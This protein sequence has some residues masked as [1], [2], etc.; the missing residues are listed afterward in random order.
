LLYAHGNKFSTFYPSKLKISEYIPSVR[1]TDF[2]LFNKSVQIGP[3]DISPLQKSISETKQIVLSHE[4]SIFTFEFATLDYSAPL[5]NM[6]AHKMDGIDP[7]WVLSDATRRF[8]TYTNL[9]P[10]EYTFLVKGSNSHGVWNEKPTSIKVIINPP[11][12]QTSWAYLIYVILFCLTIYSLRAY[13]LKRQR[14]KH[15]LELEHEHAEELEQVDQMKSKFFANISHE[16]R[17]PLTLIEGPVKQLVEGSFSG[18]IK[19]QYRLILR[20][21]RRLLRMINQILDL[22]KIDAGHMNLRAS[23][24]NVVPLLKGLVMTFASKADQKNITIDLGIAEN[25]IPLFLDKEKFETIITNLMSNALKF[26]PENGKIGVSLRITHPPSSPFF[27]GEIDSPLRE[28]ENNSKFQISKAA[29]VEISISNT[30]PH[31]PPERLDKIFNRFSHFDET[32]HSNHESTGIGL[33]LTKELVELHKGS[34]QVMSTADEGTTFSLTF[35]LGSEHLTPD[36]ILDNDAVLASNDKPDFE[37]S[38]EKPVVITP[39]PQSDKPVILMVDDNDDVRQFVHS[40]LESSFS[41]IEAENGLKGYKSAA[42][43]IPDLIIS[44]V[45]MPEM[46]GFELC[47]KLKQDERT[48][49]IPVILLTARAATPDKLRGLE[50]GADDYIAKPF[51][52]EELLIR[53]RNLIDQRERIHEHFQK[54][55]HIQPDDIPLRSLDKQFMIKAMEVI[56]GKMEDPT[57]DVEEFVDNLH[58]SRS[59]LYRKIK[60]LTGESVKHFIRTVRLNRAASILKSKSASVTETAYQVGFRNPAYFAECFQKQFGVSPSQYSRH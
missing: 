56:E 12:W 44:D 13:D 51:S 2:Q 52:T 38:P 32:K 35:H 49:H 30:G 28:S 1:I 57:F 54:E 36:Q 18:N 7:D 26:T 3:K 34:I 41:F 8:A 47:G 29:L 23:L 46:D 48:S 37:V 31:I 6:Y 20:N 27:K 45:M 40:G 42:E 5:K 15:A 17:T 53:V 16:F 39:T 33:A 50:T 22:S 59:V 9:D 43:E 11:W 21:T 55:H 10:G 25:E 58:L 14:L 24:I 19:A 4:Q 60:A